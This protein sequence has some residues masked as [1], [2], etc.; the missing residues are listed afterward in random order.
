M[1]TETHPDQFTIPVDHVSD[2]A[3][4]VSAYRL[5]ESRRPDRHFDDSLAAKLLGDKEAELMGQFS[6]WKFGEWMMAVRT[7]LIDR[8]LLQWIENGVET[9]VNLAAGLDT[10]PYRLP[11]SQKVKWIEADFD[12]IIRYKNEKL[13]GDQPNC[14]LERVSVNLADPGERS[15]F[16]DTFKDLGRFVVLTEGLLLYLN[17]EDVR[18][19]SQDLHVHS[20]L[21][22][23]LMD[24]CNLDSFRALWRFSQ[25]NALPSSDKQVSFNFLPEQ[26]AHYFESLGWKVKDF[27]SYHPY[28]KL[29]NRNFP[30]ELQKQDLEAIQGMG[31]GV[32]TRR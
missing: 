2:T 13:K 26:G 25:E 7:T 10:R 24:I 27:I 6:N 12:G 9:V 23:W 30:E 18:N 29:L 19:L 28:G 8:Q 31:L 16:F 21:E 3:Y 14:Q 20:N 15:R 22:A 11:L 17:P 5:A 1:T 4:L 32:L